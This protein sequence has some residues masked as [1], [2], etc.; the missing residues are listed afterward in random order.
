MAEGRQFSTERREDQDRLRG[1]REVLLGPDD[2]SNAH[3]DIVYDVGQNEQRRPVPFDQDKVV[4][5]LVFDR[6]FTAHQIDKSR[7]A[8]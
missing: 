1:I 3:V 7:H 2:M 8:G 6:N 5:V 4:D